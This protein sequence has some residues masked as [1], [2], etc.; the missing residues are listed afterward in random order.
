MAMSVSPI[1]CVT[2]ARWLARGIFNSVA[3]LP[4]LNC[5]PAFPASAPHP[6]KI[7]RT[8]FDTLRMI[9]SPPLKMDLSENRAGLTPHSFDGRPER[10]RVS[11]VGLVIRDSGTEISGGSGGLAVAGAVRCFSQRVEMWL[12][13]RQGPSTARADIRICGRTLEKTG[14]LRSGSQPDKRGWTQKERAHSPCGV[15]AL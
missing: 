13:S 8:H 4:F 11:Q 7:A 9:E 1:L 6:A 3:W 15:C 10:G 12:E 5:A 14:L 2:V